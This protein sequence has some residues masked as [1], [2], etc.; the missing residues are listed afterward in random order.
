MLLTHWISLVGK[1]HKWVLK[2]RSDST[3]ADLA[4]V[5]CADKIEVGEAVDGELDWGVQSGC[6]VIV[7]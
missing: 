4:Q 5:L 1:S 3:S 2:L 6:M 7:T